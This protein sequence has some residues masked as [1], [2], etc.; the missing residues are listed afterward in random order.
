MAEGYT[1][2]FF[3]MYPKI[4][5]NLWQ[6][7]DVTTL[8]K[9][10]ERS[11]LVRTLSHYHLNIISKILINTIHSFQLFPRQGI[12][13]TQARTRAHHRANNPAVII[14]YF[15]YNIEFN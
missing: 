15:I 13:H 11:N 14:F 5:P 4:Y 12:D 3:F 7:P 10:N 1:S 9:F 6:C 8:S 2:S